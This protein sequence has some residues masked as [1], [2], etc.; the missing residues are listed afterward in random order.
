VFQPA[1]LSSSEAV[2]PGGQVLLRSVQTGAFCRVA[3]VVA[4]RAG[5][6]Q[7]PGQQQ[8]GQQQPGQ[9]PPAVAAVNRRPPPRSPAASLV[10]VPTR[11]SNRSSS[12]IPDSHSA[13]PAKAGPRPP[14]DGSQPASFPKKSTQAAARKPPTSPKPPPSPH[15]PAKQTPPLARSFK[16]GQRQQ[17]PLPAASSP[18]HAAAQLRAVGTPQ[19]AAPHSRGLRRVTRSASLPPPRPS[20]QPR[21]AASAAATASATSGLGLLCDQPSADTASV[22]AYTGTGLVYQGSPLLPSGA[23]Q[24]LLVTPGGSPATCQLAQFTPGVWQLLAHQE[25]EHMHTP[26]ASACG[27]HVPLTS[28]CVCVCVCMCLA[29][30][31]PTTSACTWI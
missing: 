12:S 10:P 2:A 25:L 5:S 24:V 26:Q 22:L 16:P 20:R 6:Q 23:S 18:P 13:S 8:P 27:P 28:C 9:Q 21:L 31:T 11:S 4:L 3:D 29:H 19:P 15:Q 17:T 7:Q 14:A 1:D 30:T